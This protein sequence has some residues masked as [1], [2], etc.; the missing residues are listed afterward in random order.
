[1][2]DETDPELDAASKDQ[3]RHDAQGFRLDA[4]SLRGEAEHDRSEA[5]E[6][7][8]MGLGTDADRYTKEAATLEKRAD[9]F[10]HRAE[11]LDDAVSHREDARRALDMADRAAARATDA[12]S[13]A[14]TPQGDQDVVDWTAAQAAAA[15]EA[16]A[17]HE[18]HDSMQG[19]AK[20]ELEYVAVSEEVEARSGLP[21][22]GTDGPPATIVDPFAP[23]D[24]ATTPDP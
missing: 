8:T 18:L 20:A 12:E 15:A 5:A 23:P 22:R 17:M 6:L 14:A 2:V 19:G 16:K 3:D 21:Y 4:T 9:N 13:R 10:D 11:L 7:K 1:M 24:P